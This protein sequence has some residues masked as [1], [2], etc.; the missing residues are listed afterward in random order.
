MA[1]KRKAD[2]PT[3]GVEQFKKFTEGDDQVVLPRDCLY[4]IVSKLSFKEI[5]AS[6]VYTVS[7][8]FNRWVAPVLKCE[9]MKRNRNIQ[10]LSKLIIDFLY[11]LTEEVLPDDMSRGRYFYLEIGFS[12]EPFPPVQ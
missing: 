2:N 10:L 5:V 12:I 11:M 7:K 6:R 3:S 8:L 4:Q 9:K 1:N